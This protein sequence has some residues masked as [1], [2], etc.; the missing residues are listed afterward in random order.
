MLC[1]LTIVR[2]EKSNS[3]LICDIQVDPICCNFGHE[4][5]CAEIENIHVA[6]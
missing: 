5:G 1:V 4:F 6:T 3:V 2:L